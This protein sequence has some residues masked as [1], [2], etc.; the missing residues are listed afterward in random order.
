MQD[1]P[2][3]VVPGAFDLQTWEK[4]VENGRISPSMMANVQGTN[5]LMQP[6]AAAAMSAMI[7]AAAADGVTLTIGESYRSYEAQASAYAA[8]QSGEKK[9]PVAAPG[10]SNH[11]WGL[12]VDFVITPENHGWLVKNAARFGF[13]NPFGNSYDAVENWHWE[14]GQDG[15]APDYTQPAGAPTKKL[16]A[17][18]PLASP[19][20][21]LVPSYLAG[22]Q[23]GARQV[24]GGV[25][26]DLL[27]NERPPAK[28]GAAFG[29]SPTK[30]FSGKN[31]SINRQLYR[32]FMDAGRP[33]LAKM[34][35]T[36][37]MNAWI[38]AESGYDPHA[39]SPAN[40][41][42][43]AND[44]LFQIWRGHDFNSN[45]QVSRMSPYQ[46]AI[47][48]AEKF[49]LTAEDIRNY[50]AQIARGTYEGWG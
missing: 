21:S 40:N 5:F 36:K 48:V 7:S 24:M 3:G 43:L 28:G 47:L 13:T 27:V 49:N 29:T 37:E 26:A 32:G 1:I 22:D 2:V 34:V 46:Q 8:H 42:G 44:G 45:G 18:K 33:D 39:T 16:R 11:G 38:G 23:Y 17:P 41:Q 15:S 20:V 12:A 30:N 25:L 6:D 19:D 35:G 4:T 31:S 9:A 14:Y 10:T 50:A